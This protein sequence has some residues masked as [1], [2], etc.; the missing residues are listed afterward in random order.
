[1]EL[2]FLVLSLQ[3]SAWPESRT[4]GAVAQS[5]TARPSKTTVRFGPPNECQTA[6]KP[7]TA[8]RTLRHVCQAATIALMLAQA[9]AWPHGS[10]EHM[11]HA[12]MVTTCVCLD[13]PQTAAT[14][15][16]RSTRCRNRNL[17]RNTMLKP[18]GPKQSLKM[19]R[20]SNE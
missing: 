10:M 9:M 13:R 6:R 2:V 3:A 15:P 18:K 4:S 8:T 16:R 7:C 12:R 19:E 5:S 20:P 14:S 1:M 11:L 17:D